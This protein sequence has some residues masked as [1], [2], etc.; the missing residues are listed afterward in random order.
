[1]GG[2]SGSDS[3][4]ESE[5]ES[6]GAVHGADGLEEQPVAAEGAQQGGV[7][8]GVDREGLEHREKVCISH[9]RSSALTEKHIFFKG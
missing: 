8:L 2:A 5:S 1:M 4:S 6:G 3:D 7:G 9:K